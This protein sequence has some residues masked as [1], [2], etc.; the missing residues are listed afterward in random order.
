[1]KEE[2][3]QRFNIFITASYWVKQILKTMFEFMLK[4]MPQTSLNLVK[5]TLMQT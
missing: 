2:M 1:M 3:S 5:G 4:K